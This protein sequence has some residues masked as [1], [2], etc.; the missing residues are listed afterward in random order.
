MPIYEFRCDACGEV[1]ELLAITAKDEKGAACPQCGGEELTRVLS[2]CASVVEGSGPG[3]SP[4]A[5]VENR[6]CAGSGSCTTLTL[7]GHQR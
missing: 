3:D 4:A 5:G 1:F 6:S 7:P 2:A